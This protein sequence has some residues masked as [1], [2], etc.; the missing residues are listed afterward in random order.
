MF[1]HFTRRGR[2]MRN[3]WVIVLDESLL[4]NEQDGQ[5]TV[6]HQIAHSWLGNRVMDGDFL[7]E[8]HADRMVKA[9]GFNVPKYRPKVHAEYQRAMERSTGQGL[10]LEEDRAIRARARLLRKG[11]RAK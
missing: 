6:A 2:T 9:M 5:Y 10:S 8:E 7:A 3:H 11:A 1:T 4:K